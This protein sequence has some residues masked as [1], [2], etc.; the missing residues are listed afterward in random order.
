MAMVGAP[1]ILASGH[2]LLQNGITSSGRGGHE[3]N[4]NGRNASRICQ[5]CDEPVTED[6]PHLLFKCSHFDCL[7]QDLWGRVK[8][9]APPAMLHEINKMSSENVSILLLLGLN[10]KYVPEWSI[11]YSAMCYYIHTMYNERLTYS[12][13]L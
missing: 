6:V 2:T 10:C 13:Y 8:A 3:L 4:S 1:R 12:S 9:T 5:N 7:G 11:V